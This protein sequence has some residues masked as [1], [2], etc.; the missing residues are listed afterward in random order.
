MSG[1]QGRLLV[2]P[3]DEEQDEYLIIRLH[4]GPE[5]YDEVAAIE[6]SVDRGIVLT[7]LVAGPERA[8]PLGEIIHMDRITADEYHERVEKDSNRWTEV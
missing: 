4:A 6:A 2:A 1:V 3:D 5:T 8:Y 7:K